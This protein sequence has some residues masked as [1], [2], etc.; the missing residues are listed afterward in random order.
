MMLMEC[1]LNISTKLIA[2]FFKVSLSK[3]RRKERI[4]QVLQ[5]NMYCVYEKD[6]SQ[7]IHIA[8]EILRREK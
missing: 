3:R 8:S 1:N 2:Q 5:E 4:Q 7:H 6:K